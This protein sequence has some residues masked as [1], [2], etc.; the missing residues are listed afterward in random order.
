LQTGK[1]CPDV[2]EVLVAQSVG[3]GGLVF[4]Q[5]S[6]GLGVAVGGLGVAVAG[7]GV[8]VAGL[9]VAVGNVLLQTFLVP[10]EQIQVLGSSQLLSVEQ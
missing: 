10:L 6:M 5:C 8:A 3:L 4:K 2:Q 9:G 7:L 1:H